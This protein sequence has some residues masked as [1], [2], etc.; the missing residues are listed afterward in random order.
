[1]FGRGLG[2]VTRLA[3]WADVLKPRRSGP[4]VAVLT[5]PTP[6]GG[7]VHTGC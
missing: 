4:S 7:A 6:P 2:R 3:R 1:V 5:G